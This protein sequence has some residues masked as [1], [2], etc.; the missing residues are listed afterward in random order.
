MSSSFY[1]ELPSDGDEP[2]KQELPIL[3][4]V[5]EFLEEVGEPPKALVEGV[6]LDYSLLALAA[7]PK[8]LKSF[9]ALD[10]ADAICRGRDVFD[11]F[12]VNRPGPVV[13]L[14]MEDGQFEIAKRLRKR[15]IKPGDVRPLY[16]CI[17]RIP[18]GTPGG[19]AMLEKLIADI[20][21][22]LIIVD[23]AREALGI[24]IGATPPSSW[25]SCA[26]CENLPA[27][28]VPYC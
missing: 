23:T 22:V 21:P 5:G 3:I 2:Q 17:K 20:K 18:L 6:L 9:T 1:H 16:I 28:T 10:I 27:S 24:G 14:G 12:K 8:H 15:G 4:Q 19:V 26:R 13:Y 25:R 11:N 7:K